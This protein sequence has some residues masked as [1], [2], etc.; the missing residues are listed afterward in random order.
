M[1]RA[2]RAARLAAALAGLLASPAA[3]CLPDAAGDALPGSRATDATSASAAW[4][5]DPTAI[6]GHG[7]MGAVADA[8]TLAAV[9]YPDTIDCTVRRAAAGP[10]HVFEDIAPRLH[11]LDGD[12]RP[13][14]IAVRSSLTEGAQ[15][16]VYAARGDGLDLI[17]ATP[18]IG[19]RNRWLAPA[20]I[21]D[22]DG[23]GAVEIAYVDRPHLA[24][25]LRVWR[26]TDGGLVELLATA[27]RVTNHRI[28][29]EVI[30]GGLIF[31]GAQ[32][33]IVLASGDWTR[34]LAL[35]LGP[36]GFAIRDIGPWRDGVALTCAG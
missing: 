14:V 33:E 2:A 23:D 1:R 7:I 26:W 3:A 28:G 34:R 16:A 18:F 9:L 29:D 19:R 15:L 32:P 20:A 4:Y 5:E 25:V 35:R 8:A 24:R 10:G 13:E 21:A 11:D 22:L 31:C 12:D 6:Y 17:A 27:E 30:R 36:D